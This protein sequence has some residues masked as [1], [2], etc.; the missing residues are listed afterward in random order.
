MARLQY[1]RRCVQTRS[2]GEVT[3]AQSR[4]DDLRVKDVRLENR[5]DAETQHNESSN[6]QKLQPQLVRRSFGNAEQTTKIWH[7]ATDIRNRRNL[8]RHGSIVGR[9]DVCLDLRSQPLPFSASE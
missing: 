8:D 3:A 7:C 1:P 5:V 6:K 4:I 9:A 2:A